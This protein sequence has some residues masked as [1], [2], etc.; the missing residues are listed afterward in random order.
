MIYDFKVYGTGSSYYFHKIDDYQYSK[1]KEFENS[2][3]DIPIKEIYEFLQIQDYRD[4][5]I[6]VLNTVDGYLTV[7]YDDYAYYWS[8]EDDQDFK[9]ETIS[10]FFDFGDGHFFIFSEYQLGLF[11]F[12]KP[13]LM[14]DFDPKKLKAKKIQILNDKLSLISSLTYNA[15]HLNLLTEPQV[16]WGNGSG[17][18]YYLI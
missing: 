15:M 12:A 8:S 9:F 5:T 13:D 16:I 7:D 1:L 4:T 10:N 14:N 6:K 18:T 3:N 2:L 11:S 17:L